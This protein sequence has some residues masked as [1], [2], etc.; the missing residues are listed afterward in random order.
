MLKQVWKILEDDK[1]R[2]VTYVM[3]ISTNFVVLIFIKLYNNLNISFS[4]WILFYFLWLAVYK[5]N[6]SQLDDL[7]LPNFPTTQKINYNRD[8]VRLSNEGIELYQ[9][10]IRVIFC[11]H[12]GN[13]NFVSNI[14]I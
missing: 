6:H 7:I 12:V 13:I 3:V 5:W 10:D 4:L 9:P 2:I 11:N 1:I 8:Y 14:L